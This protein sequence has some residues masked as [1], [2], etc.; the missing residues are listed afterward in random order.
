MQRDV[1]EPWPKEEGKREGEGKGEGGKALR[2]APGASVR[3]FSVDYPLLAAKLICLLGLLC[4]LWLI[5]KYVLVVFL[6]FL[7]AWGLAFLV[8][9]RNG[10]LFL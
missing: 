6:P 10:G 9:P 2:E 8:H 5:F 3:G 4:L 1:K 7:L